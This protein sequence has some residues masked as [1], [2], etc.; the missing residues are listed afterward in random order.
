MPINQTKLYNQ[1]L[2]LEYMGEGQ[3]NNSLRLIF[4]RDIEDNGNLR[5]QGRQISPNKLQDDATS[6]NVLFTHLTCT[7]LD[8]KTMAREFDIARSKRLHWI[9][10]HVDGVCLHHCKVFSCIDRNQ[11]DS[12]DEVRTYIF[13][14]VES[15]LIVLRPLRNGDGYYL[16]TAH[17]LDGRDPKKIDKKYK[18]R[19]P[20]LH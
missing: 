16:L 3:R 14:E 5:F 2:E 17:Y 15:Y 7:V 8:Y 4:K 20:E 12:R 1:L 13:N 18:R 10:H 19:L 11:K 9:K 6:L